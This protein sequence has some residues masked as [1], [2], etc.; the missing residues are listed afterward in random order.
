MG[1]YAVFLGISFT[2]DVAML[3]ALDAGA[4]DINKTVTVKLPLAIPYTPNDVEFERVD[5]LF[6]YRGEHYRL[7]KQRFADDTLTIVCVVD[8][9]RKKIQEE[10][11]GYVETFTDKAP[12]GSQAKRTINFTKDYLPLYI[13]MKQATPGWVH[14]EILPVVVQQKPAYSFTSLATPP[15]KTIS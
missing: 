15:P 14:E 13:A 12:V 11:T 8:A 5:G 6:T 10:L 9:G 4:Y 3:Q 1:Y 2:H 7:V